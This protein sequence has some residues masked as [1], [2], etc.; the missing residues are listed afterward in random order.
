M[1]WKEESLKACK[2]YE[3][4]LESFLV[5]DNISDK[6]LESFKKLNYAC[7]LNSDGFR[8]KEFSK[9]HFQKHV[10]FAGCSN[11]FGH[12]SK[13]E[14]VWS[15]QLYTKLTRHEYLSGYFNLG[16]P[17]GT[18][19]EIITNIYRYIRKYSKP[20]T[21]FLLLPELERDAQYLKHPDILLT[22]FVIEFYKQ[23]EDYCIS[24][25]IKLI[26]TSWFLNKEFGW[27]NLNLKKPDFKL[28]D[29]D[30][31]IN[32]SEDT[33][34]YEFKNRNPYS[35]LLLL[36]K[37]T[38]TFKNIDLDS[39]FKHIHDYSEK[40]KNRKD[41]LTT[42]DGSNHYGIAFHNAWAEV[43]YERYKNEKTNIQN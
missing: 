38:Q 39:L 8:S 32:G 11:T 26:S 28:T 2:R 35:Q 34:Y 41:L 12:G 42:L 5:D 30:G 6:V 14:E 15:Y 23:F 18:V 36:E 17:G 43:I 21:I 19:I 25:N 4:K 1:D 10:I 7:V 22:P 40:N 33:P 31:T 9:K 29:P 37:N 27:Q 16:V 13:Y 20:D 24:N 3:S